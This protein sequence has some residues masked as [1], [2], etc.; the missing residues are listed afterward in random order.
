MS[1]LEVSAGSSESTCNIEGAMLWQISL[2]NGVLLN[3]AAASIWL[4]LVGAIED[5]DVFHHLLADVIFLG[6]VGDLS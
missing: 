3:L 2:R 1:S 6:L 4:S 5:L